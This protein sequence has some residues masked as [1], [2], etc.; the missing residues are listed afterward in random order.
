MSIVDQIWNSC[1]VSSGKNCSI[2]CNV[3]T[4]SKFK[5]NA[6]FIHLLIMHCLCDCIGD[7]WF[8]WNVD[9]LTA[10]MK[11]WKILIRQD[12]FNTTYYPLWTFTCIM[13]TLRYEIC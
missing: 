2:I 8:N 1:V 3:C 10:I 12:M 7:S 9:I 6:L 5:S 11:M 13:V 4:D